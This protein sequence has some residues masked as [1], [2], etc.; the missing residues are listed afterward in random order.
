MWYAEVLGPDYG[1]YSISYCGK[2]DWLICNKYNLSFI[3]IIYHHKK[4][5]PIKLKP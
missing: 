5:F 2:S 3:L 1:I 4:I